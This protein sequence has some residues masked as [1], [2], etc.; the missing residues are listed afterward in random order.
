MLKGIYTPVSG[1][2][3]QEK[4]LEIIANNLA[5]VNTT[6]FKGDKVSFTLQEPEPDKHYISPLP[7]ANYKVNMEHMNPLVGNEMAYV[8]VADVKSDFT[9]GAAVE[10][11]NNADLMIDGDG[12]FVINTPQGE[13]YSRDGAFKVSPDGALVNQ[14][15]L[16]VLGENG[17][18]Y[19]NGSGFSVNQDGQVFMNDRY[20][21]KIMLRSFSDNNQLERVGKNQYVY[22]GAPDTVSPSK[23]S[24]RQGYLEG[25]NVNAIQ[26]MTA[27]IAA[28]R[29]YEAYQ[30][31]IKNYDN[32]MEKS[33]NSIGEVKA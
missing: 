23:A 17:V 33:A 18:I 7:P 2:T 10:T 19:V 6:G 1:A 26:N 9:Q 22:T 24:L 21:D 11:G 8:G 20:V 16:P 5:N 29:S 31:A 28:H 15:G 27:M 4:V 12:F 14:D 13:R 3:A 25:S 32:M 30:K